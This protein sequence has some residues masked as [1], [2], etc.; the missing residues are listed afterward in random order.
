MQRLNDPS[1]KFE[2]TPKL[3][4]PNE[5]LDATE[6]A[7]RVVYYE[8]GGSSSQVA[9]LKEFKNDDKAEEFTPNPKPRHLA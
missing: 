2:L 9:F 7:K 8:V 4:C 3:L 1:N 5:E 6:C